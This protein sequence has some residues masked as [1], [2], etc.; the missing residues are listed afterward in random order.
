MLSIASSKSGVS[1]EELEHFV[2]KMANDLQYAKTLRNVCEKQLGIPGDVVASEPMSEQLKNS[3]ALYE[4]V[5]REGDW[6]EC[7]PSRVLAL[8]L[9]LLTGATLFQSMHI[10]LLPCIMVNSR[11]ALHESKS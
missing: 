1:S 2:G 10:A 9:G 11:L 8:G 6:L 4:R 5:A 7:V 3:I